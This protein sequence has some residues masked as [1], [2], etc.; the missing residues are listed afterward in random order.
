LNSE[1]PFGLNDPEFKDTLKEIL[2]DDAQAQ[3]AMQGLQ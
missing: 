3:E 2:N 1:D